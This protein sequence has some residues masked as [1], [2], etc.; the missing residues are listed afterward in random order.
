[1]QAWIRN[2]SADVVGASLRDRFVENYERGTLLTPVQS[3]GSL[4]ERL[5]GDST[6]EIWNAP[7]R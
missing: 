2:Q 7:D 1:M 6:G 5:A 4:L 3:A